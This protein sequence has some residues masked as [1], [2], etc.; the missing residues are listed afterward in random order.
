MF[1]N[2]SDLLLDVQGEVLAGVGTKA[3]ALRRHDELKSRLGIA[4]SRLESHRSGVLNVS[5]EVLAHRTVGQCRRMTA[6]RARLGMG[7]RLSESQAGYSSCSERVRC[8]PGPQ[9]NTRRD[10]ENAARQFDEVGGLTDWTVVHL[11]GWES[12]TVPPHDFQ[13]EWRVTARA[14]NRQ[15]GDVLVQGLLDCHSW[16]SL[17]RTR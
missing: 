8:Q 16:E 3:M 1:R 9:Y 15:D 4:Q 12:D 14:T 2:L 5:E 6:E 17:T 11:S 7:R 10:P 13:L